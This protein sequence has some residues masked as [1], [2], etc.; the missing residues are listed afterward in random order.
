M[1]KKAAAS[2]GPASDAPTHTVRDPE[3]GRLLTLKGYGALKGQFM[4]REGIDLTKPIAEQVARLERARERA[5]AARNRA[6]AAK[7]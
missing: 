1:A 2:G 6:V 3:T 7:K 4:V 5:D